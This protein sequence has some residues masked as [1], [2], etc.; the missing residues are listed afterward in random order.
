MKLKPLKY[1]EFIAKLIKLGYR[2]PFPGGKHPYFLLGKRSVK[3]PN[4][5]GKDVTVYILKNI[6]KKSGITEDEFLNL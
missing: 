2:G 1:R 5:H 6:I 3:V 4:P